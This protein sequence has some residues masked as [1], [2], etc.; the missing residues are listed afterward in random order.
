MFGLVL[1]ASILQACVSEDVA[2]PLFD[3][4]A[5]H[6]A[7][8][9]APPIKPTPPNPAAISAPGGVEASDV[10]FQCALCP[11]L[12]RN[13]EFAG[14]DEGIGGSS[15]PTL[16]G[17][18]PGAV[19]VAPKHPREHFSAATPTAEPASPR[20]AFGLPHGGSFGA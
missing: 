19:A 7:A 16:S 8:S 15:S 3:N 17:A 18:G 1:F 10:F 9:T 5:A 11:R 20:D 2:A 13:R 12:V 14:A 4:D 6:F